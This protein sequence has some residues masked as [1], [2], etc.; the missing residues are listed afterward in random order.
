M[1]TIQSANTNPFV[2]KLRSIDGNPN[3]PNPGAANFGNQ[4]SQSWVIA[5]AAGG[6]TNFNAAKFT[7]DTSA[8]ANDLAGGTFS[9]R[10]NDNSLLLVFASQPAPPVFGSVTLTGDGVVVGGN[11]GVTGGDYYL[12]A[13]TNLELPLAEWT[14]VATNQFGAGGSFLFTNALNATGPQLFY[15]LMVP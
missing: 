7:V 10:T 13:A 8:F 9:V 12:L 15:R 14:R 11:G 2:I 1:L 4:S 6:I 5:T 3:D